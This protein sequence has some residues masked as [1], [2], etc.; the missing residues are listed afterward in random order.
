MKLKD[1]AAVDE[2]L[3]RIGRLQ[4]QRQ[5]IQAELDESVAAARAVFEKRAQPLLAEVAEL[6]AA[7][8]RWCAAHRGEVL[9]AG[10]KTARFP[11]GEVS[12][13]RAPPAVELVGK[14]EEALAELRANGLKRLIEVKRVESLDRRAIL[15]RPE[16]VAGLRSLRVPPEAERPE[17][18]TIKPAG[19]KLAETLSLGSG[20]AGT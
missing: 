18:V 8:A 17:T 11:A 3:A 14:L 16:L 1:R 20:D 19:S 5:G 9:P 12:F 7:V 10:S 6:A 2:A 4:R 13:R 15:A